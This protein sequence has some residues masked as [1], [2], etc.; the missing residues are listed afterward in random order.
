MVPPV[1]LVVVGA[2]EVEGPELVGSVDVGDEDDVLL[3]WSSSTVVD[4]TVVRGTL[5]R[6]AVVAEPDVPA[7]VVDALPLPEPPLEEDGAGSLDDVV[8]MEVAVVV[9]ASV[10]CGPS[11]ALMLDEAASDGCV[12]S[13]RRGSQSAGAEDS[14]RRGNT[15][16]RTANA[17]AA[18]MPNVTSHATG[19]VSR[20]RPRNAPDHVDVAAAPPTDPGALDARESAP[21]PPEAD[22]RSGRAVGGVGPLFTH[23]SSTP[24]RS[25]RKWTLVLVPR[26]RGVPGHAPC[27]GALSAATASSR[28]W[29][30]NTLPE[31]V[32]GSGS[33]NTN[34]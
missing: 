30:L 19:I 29:R 1:A 17:L 15:T 3:P 14:P 34:R 24:A 6:G 12:S 16:S 10:R 27:V 25:R 21:E 4:G 8:T 5:L 32:R 23:S 33:G 26:T 20:R 9:T 7:F 28:S 18:Q 11:T 31:P 22:G 2:S 13:L